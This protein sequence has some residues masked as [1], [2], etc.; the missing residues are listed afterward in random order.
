M[1]AGGRHL[2][3][4]RR[5]PHTYLRTSRR[6]LCIIVGQQDDRELLGRRRIDTD[7][8]AFKLARLLQQ[9]EEA[10]ILQGGGDVDRSHSEGAEAASAATTSSSIL[11]SRGIHWYNKGTR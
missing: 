4:S 10:E 9:L 5:P 11:L 7:Q 6:Q 1:G 8:D 3:V 2:R